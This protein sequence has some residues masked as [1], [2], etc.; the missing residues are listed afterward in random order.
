M[1]YDTNIVEIENVLIEERVGLFSDYQP[2]D[3]N[4]KVIHFTDREGAEG[5]GRD[6]V[7]WCSS[8]AK[9]CYVV[10]AGERHYSSTSQTRFGRARNR[11]SAV[12]GKI[13]WSSVREGYRYPDELVLLPLNGISIKLLEVE[14]VSAHEAIQL[15]R[16][17]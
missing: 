16:K 3:Y 14:V 15:L 5:I 10:I 9:G 7:L 17:R 1:I 6:G 4:G 8:F 13:D 12:I 11:L 2:V